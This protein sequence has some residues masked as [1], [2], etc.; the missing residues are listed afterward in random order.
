[1]LVCV[2]PATRTGR[3]LNLINL[4][5]LRRRCILLLGLALSPCCCC[6][7]CHCFSFRWWCNA[8][9]LAQRKIWKQKLI[10]SNQIKFEIRNEKSKSR[11]AGSRDSSQ[12]NFRVAYA[13][14]GA[15]T[16]C[17][18]LLW[19]PAWPPP[20]CS[21]CLVAWGWGGENTRNTLT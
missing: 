16:C 7:C 3:I 15:G 11:S 20:R 17:T 1:M 9:R 4:N 19:P 13:Q 14:C 18:T 12:C 10:K 8:I 21:Q 6:C 5:R 2:L